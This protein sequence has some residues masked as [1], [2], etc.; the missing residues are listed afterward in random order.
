LA[1]A[2]QAAEIQK[3]PDAAKDPWFDGAPFGYTLVAA[4]RGGTKLESREVQNIIRKWGKGRH[5]VDVRRNVAK[6]VFA[7]V[8]SSIAA[9]LVAVLASILAT[10]LDKQQVSPRSL[11][12]SSAGT[13]PDQ[14]ESVDFQARGSVLSGQLIQDLRSQGIHIP[15]YAVIV[16]VGEPQGD[17]PA[18]QNSCRTAR[19]FYVL[20][21]DTY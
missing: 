16:G 10:Q 2:L 5:A 15:G 18:L 3:N 19:Q 12:D 11:S 14:D 21:R 20:L 1:A 4:P 6:R 13:R 9:L 17:F 8:G 7:I